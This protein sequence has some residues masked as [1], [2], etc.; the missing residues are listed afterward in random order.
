MIDANKADPWVLE[1]VDIGAYNGVFTGAGGAENLED[2][3]SRRLDEYLG[4]AERF[5]GDLKARR[6]R[7]NE[8][9]QSAV[10]FFWT[11][12]HGGEISDLPGIPKYYRGDISFSPESTDLIRKRL[13]EIFQ[14][15]RLSNLSIEQLLQCLEPERGERGRLDTVIYDLEKFVTGLLIKSPLGGSQLPEEASCT[16]ERAMLEVVYGAYLGDENPEILSC[17]PEQFLKYL[18]IKEVVEGLFC[19]AIYGNTTDLVRQIEALKARLLSF[20]TSICNA[21]ADF[22][23]RR[24]IPIY[25]KAAAGFFAN[26]KEGS[27]EVSSENQRIIAAFFGFAFT[28]MQLLPKI[29]EV[30]SLSVSDNG[31]YL[32]EG[33]KI[34]RQFLATFG[35]TSQ[36]DL[37]KALGMLQNTSDVSAPA[38][39]G[40]IESRD[41]LEGAIDPEHPVVKDRV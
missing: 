12:T 34:V 15:S 38:A 16:L 5:L 6:V 2:S 22:E 20:L 26:L 17:T 3:E 21:G 27:L 36:G 9:T 30:E 41:M 23:C 13:A 37:Q 7:D 4:A 8:G 29:G 25:L 39:D 40:M 10:R 35:F 11:S 1:H 14:N 31:F 19:V 24:G 28:A 32:E 33:Q 18:K